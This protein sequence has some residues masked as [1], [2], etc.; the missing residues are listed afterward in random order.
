MNWGVEMA[1][2]VN[3]TGGGK[4]EVIYCPHVER[5]H[6]HTMLFLLDERDCQK[7]VW[8]CLCPICQDVVFAGVVSQ[9][10]R[11]GVRNAIQKMGPIRVE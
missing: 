2:V 3:Q 9:I 8:L 4:R 1:Q 10:M 6:P 5:E 11:R 7:T